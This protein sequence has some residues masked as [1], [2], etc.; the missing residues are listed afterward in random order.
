MREGSI[1]PEGHKVLEV[2][3]A[4]FKVLQFAERIDELVN[5]SCFGFFDYIEL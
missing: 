4:E 1:T 5:K 3:A 2:L